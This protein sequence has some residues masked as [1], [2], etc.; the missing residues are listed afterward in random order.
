MR[1]EIG[2]YIIAY[3]EVCHGKPIFKG[4]RILVSDVIELLVASVSIKEIIGDYYPILN[5]DMIKETLD[6]A[7]KI[8]G[9]EHHVGYSE[10]PF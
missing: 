2:K 10:V 4:T 5:E 8:I 6:W 3:D 7:V 9:G 1:V